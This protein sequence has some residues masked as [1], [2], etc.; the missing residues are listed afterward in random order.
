MLSLAVPVEAQSRKGKRSVSRNKSQRN[1]AR[2]SRTQSAPE[3]DYAIVPDEIEVLEY[4]SSRTS[5]L[6]RW[7]NPPAPR[8][9]GPAL[10]AE[11]AAISTV[12]RRAVKMDSARVIQIQQALARQGYFSGEM[13]GV[14]D[15]ATVDAMRRFQLD[16]RIGATGY[17]TAQALKRLGL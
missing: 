15:D 7:L 5:D 3:S 11:P 17:P 8:L 10:A 2:P 14:Y 4:G 13:S 9:A 6:A 12:K 16:H 1:A